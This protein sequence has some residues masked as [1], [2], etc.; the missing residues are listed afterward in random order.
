MASLRI[1]QPLSLLAMGLRPFV[2]LKCCILLV[3]STFYLCMSQKLK[4]RY[5]SCFNIFGL[6]LCFKSRDWLNPKC[7]SIS[8]WIFKSLLFHSAE[9]SEPSSSFL[10]CTLLPSP[11]VGCGKC[12]VG[13]CLWFFYCCCRYWGTCTH[14]L[15]A[16]LAEVHRVEP[17]RC[18]TKAF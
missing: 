9:T 10:T 11:S 4:I 2:S 15:G 18:H 12:R 14:F 13:Q 3:Q 1:Y 17:C 8:T 16:L 7:F 5:N 6:L